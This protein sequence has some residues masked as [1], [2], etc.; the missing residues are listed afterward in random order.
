M[1]SKSKTM[2]DKFERPLF[3]KIIS[4]FLARNNVYLFGAHIFAQNL[5]SFGLNQSKIKFILDNDTDKHNKRLYGSNLFVK[6]RKI[7]EDISNPVVILSA[8]VYNDEIKKD[9]IDNI[10]SLTIFI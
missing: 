5:L 9:I 3:Q 8:G 7:L 4:D 2:L 10:N 6:S 1:T